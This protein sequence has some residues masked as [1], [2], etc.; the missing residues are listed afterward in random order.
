MV[1]PVTV[2]GEALPEPVRP[3]GLEV[4]VYSEI[5]LPPSEAD[6]V[7][8]TTACAFPATAETPVGAS[9]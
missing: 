6:A 8:E 1:S 5:G 3:P 2:I 4:T 7:N 9:A